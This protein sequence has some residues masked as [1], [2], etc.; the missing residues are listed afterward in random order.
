MVGLSS[1]CLREKII[2]YQKSMIANTLLQKAVLQQQFMVK[3]E[4]LSIVKYRSLINNFPYLLI[5]NFQ[6]THY[7]I[8]K[9]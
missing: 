7:H 2:S 8:R 6:Q 1:L 9:D 5:D 4:P 3:M